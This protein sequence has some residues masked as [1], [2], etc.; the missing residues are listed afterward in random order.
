MMK[1]WIVLFSICFACMHQNKECFDIILWNDSLKKI[2]SKSSNSSQLNYIGTSCDCFN[3][4]DKVL[5]EIRL[6]ID[7]TRI[8]NQIKIDKDLKIQKRIYRKFEDPNILR[9]RDTTVSIIP[10]NMEQ[11]KMEICAIDSNNLVLY[12]KYSEQDVISYL[13]VVKYLAND[14]IV[15]EGIDLPVYFPEIGDFW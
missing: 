10:N 9:W 5:L 4:W 11:L 3:N 14:S 7:T 13:R 1:K 12:D 6:L 15:I 8:L 2:P